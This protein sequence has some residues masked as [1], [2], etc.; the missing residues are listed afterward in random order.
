MRHHTSRSR[1]AASRSVSIPAQ[2]RA[3][4]VDRRKV[5]LAAY[6]G[7]RRHHSVRR[8]EAQRREL[9]FVKRGLGAHRG[10]NLHRQ[11]QPLRRDVVLE[12]FAYFLKKY[13]LV[14]RVRG[15]LS[16]APLGSRKS[17]IPRRSA[18]R[19]FSSEFA[20]AP[21][22]A[23]RFL[24]GRRRSRQARR[25]ARRTTARP[26]SRLSSTAARRM[27]KTRPAAAPA[28]SKRRRGACRAKAQAAAR[29]RPGL[30]NGAAR[31]RPARCR[32]R[33]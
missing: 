2:R 20:E 12:A 31:R 30:S 6:R 3:Q 28:V 11:R 17:G 26:S 5:S 15:P 13:A 14:R 4:H 32:R 25:R 9:L 7:H 24:R 19:I 16:L 33:F 23:R 8:L 27:G 29:R 10:G 22:A 1:F 21:R 18:Q